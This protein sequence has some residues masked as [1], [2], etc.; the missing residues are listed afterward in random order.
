MYMSNNF[1]HS[2]QFL[3]LTIPN[4]DLLL[5]KERK[6]N[7]EVKEYQRVDWFDHPDTNPDV[8]VGKPRVRNPPAPPVV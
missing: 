6:K 3:N 5:Y 2:L 1:D 4:S 8:L 7:D